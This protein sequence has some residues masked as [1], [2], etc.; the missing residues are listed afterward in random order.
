MFWRV[1]VMRST[2]KKNHQNPSTNKKSAGGSKSPP[3]GAL[4]NMKDVGI[5][6]VNSLD[7]K[8]KRFPKKQK[9]IVFT[10]I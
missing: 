10:F 9:Q 8:D 6:R 5:P 2:Q 7:I 1:D 3:L 4:P